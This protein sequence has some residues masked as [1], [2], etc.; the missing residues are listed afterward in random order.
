MRP[1]PPRTRHSAES[2]NPRAAIGLLAIALLLL[3]AA[4]TLAAEPPH[5]ER[6]HDPIEEI[7]FRPVADAMEP[8]YLRQLELKVGDRAFTSDLNQAAQRLNALPFIDQATV[9]QEGPVLHVDLAE[10]PVLYAVPVPLP[11]ISQLGI[12]TGLEEW[13]LAQHYWLAH[14]QLFYFWDHFRV[15]DPTNLTPVKQADH[16]DDYVWG[17]FDFGT[18]VAPDWR[19]VLTGEDY[20]STLGALTGTYAPVAQANGNTFMMGPEL[21]YD[22]ADDPAFPRLGTRFR[23]GTYFGSSL[24]G[25][26][27]DF[28]IY[29]GEIQRYIPISR[30]ECLLASL[31]GGIG[32]GVVPWHEKFQAGGNVELRGYAYQR[33]LGDRLVAGTLEYRRILYG[34]SSLLDAKGPGITGG[35]FLDVGRAWESTL[36]TPFLQDLRPSAGGYLALTW[37][38]THIGRLEAGIGSE[39]PLITTAFGMPFDW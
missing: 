25:N 15:Y 29:R 2:R 5:L 33:F 37:G 26:P 23:I 8:R 10:K 11:I 24:F 16:V 1:R 14:A 7:D 28:T 3:G 31:T 38:R 21:R 12:M 4:P 30:T 19:L 18:Q 35:M 32:R 36:G 13:H 6:A 22:N 20:L 39:G 17:N 34:G 9:S 27:N